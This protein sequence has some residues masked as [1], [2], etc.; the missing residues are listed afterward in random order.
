MHFAE[1]TIAVSRLLEQETGSGAPCHSSIFLKQYKHSPVP[2]QSQKQNTPE[3]QKTATPTA[4]K[5]TTFQNL[6]PV[7]STARSGLVVVLLA[8]IIVEVIPRVLKPLW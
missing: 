6:E 4:S 5:T 1:N 2:A 7:L 3:V 8:F